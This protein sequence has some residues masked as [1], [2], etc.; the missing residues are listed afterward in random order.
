MSER[1]DNA[2]AWMDAQDALLPAP[3]RGDAGLDAFHWEI[4]TGIGIPAHA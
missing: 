3:A 1:L 2:R 4:A